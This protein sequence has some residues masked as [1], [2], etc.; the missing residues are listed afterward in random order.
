MWDSDRYE[1]KAVIKK[2]GRVI[3]EEKL[4]FSGKPSFF[5]ASFT[6][7]EKG[8]YDVLVY[9]YNPDNGNTG[10]DRASFTIK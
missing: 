2:S 4:R 7:K 1:I 9:A 6:A 5:T 8:K 10:I 3:S